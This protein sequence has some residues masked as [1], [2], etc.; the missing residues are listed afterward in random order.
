MLDF[1]PTDNLQTQPYACCQA[2]I[3]WEACCPLSEDE[4]QVGSI[5]QSW[6]E[7]QQSCDGEREEDNILAVGAL[8]LW[9]FVVSEKEKCTY[10]L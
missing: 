8:I 4:G 1:C 7:D 5:G 10:L 6:L 3:G 2:P 9:L